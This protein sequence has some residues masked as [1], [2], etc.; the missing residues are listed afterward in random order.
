MTKYAFSCGY[1]SEE[2]TL[3]QQMGL[4]HTEEAR[5]ELHGLGGDPLVEVDSE[6]LGQATGMAEDR[7]ERHGPS[8]VRLTF[9]HWFMLSTT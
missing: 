4:K 5:R 3:S 8:A 9:G 6:G 7:G 1:W 2:Y